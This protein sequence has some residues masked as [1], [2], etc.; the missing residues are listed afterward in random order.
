MNVTASSTSWARSTDRSWRRCRVHA[1]QTP[2]QLPQELPLAAAHLD[3][4]LIPES[5]AVRKIPCEPLGVLLE[6]GRMVQR[7]LVCRV[8]GHERRVEGGVEDQPATAAQNETHVASRRVARRVCRR[9]QDVAVGGMPASSKK[10]FGDG[11]PHTGHSTGLSAKRRSESRVVTELPTVGIRSQRSKPPAIRISSHD[12]ENDARSGPNAE[13]PRRQG[14]RPAPPFF[15]LGR[16]KVRESE[17]F[18]SRGGTTGWGPSET[19]SFPDRPIRAPRGETFA[20]PAAIHIKPELCNRGNAIRPDPERRTSHSESSHSRRRRWQP[21]VGRNRNQAQ[22]DG[23][24]RR[25][26]DS[27]A[28]HEAL[29]QVRLQ[30]LRDRARLQGRPHQALHARLLDFERRPARR[31]GPLPGV[32]PERRPRRLARRPG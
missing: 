13:A 31:S 30:G 4:H 27:L 11:C 14:G 17:A 15:Y 22:A 25:Q 18:F 1:R 12:L 3:D 23:R 8:V 19:H 21:P 16:T 6:S 20:K 7:V 2:T 26:A 9:P 32:A 10:A 28:H 5:Q 24:S 29:R